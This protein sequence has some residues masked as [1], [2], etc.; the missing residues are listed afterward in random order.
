M[1]ADEYVI[2]GIIAAAERL[3]FFTF[4]KGL[5]CPSFLK[6]KLRQNI[7]ITAPD[8]GKKGGTIL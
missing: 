8:Q 7:N 3:R 6:R 5:L 1:L 2:K 4:Q